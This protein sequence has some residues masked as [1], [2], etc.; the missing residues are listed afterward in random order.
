MKSDYKTQLWYHPLTEQER[1]VIEALRE[2][3]RAQ[4]NMNE[5]QLQVHELN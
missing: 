4:G 3:Q 5:L 2:A 1:G